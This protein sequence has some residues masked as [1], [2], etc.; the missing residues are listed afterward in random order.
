MRRFLLLLLALFALAQFIRPDTT[1]PTTDPAL[2]LITITQPSAEV[3]A[4]LRT[5]CYDCHSNKTKYPW[6]VNITPVNWWLQQ[7]VNEGRG[8][9]NLSQWGALPEG[10]RAHFVDEAAELIEEGEMPLPSYTWA[11]DDARLD[12]RQ[13]K[14]LAEFF[15]SLP[16]AAIEWRRGK[17][18]PEAGEA[19]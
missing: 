7:H 14:L 5:A 16:E 3:A 11:H 4:L 12:Q 1:A 18:K 10:K 15:Q 8:E 17:R 9:G 13:R 2:D 19:H 6:Y